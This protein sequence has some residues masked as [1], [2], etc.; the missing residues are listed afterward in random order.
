MYLHGTAD[1][2][3]GIELAQGLDQFLAE[4]SDVTLFDGLN[5][6]LHLED[7]DAVNKR[8]LEFIRV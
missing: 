7:P 1:N 3:L 6:F 4:G 2:A 8:I 5:H